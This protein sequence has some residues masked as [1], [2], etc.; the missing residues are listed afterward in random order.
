MPTS[1]RVS[2]IAR[3]ASLYSAG[4]QHVIVIRTQ[5]LKVLR[6]AAC[7]MIDAQNLNDISLQSIGD[8]EGRLG[9]DELTCARDAAGAPDLR[10]VRK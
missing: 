1:L 3:T 8:D 9:D 7:P 4:T 5:P 10:I 6:P 2:R